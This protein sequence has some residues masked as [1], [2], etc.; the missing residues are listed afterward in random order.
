MNVGKQG[1][2]SKACRNKKNGGHNQASLVKTLENIIVVVLEANLIGNTAEWIVDTGATRHVCT[3]KN[4]FASYERVNGENVFMGNSAS[5]AVQAKGKIILKLTSGKSLTLINVLHMPEMRRNLIYGSLLMKAGLK[6]S[7]DSDRLIITQNGDFSGKD[8]VMGGCLL[9]MLSMKLSKDEAEGI[10][11][12][13]KAEVENQPDKK[14]KRLRSDRGG[15]QEIVRIYTQLHRPNQH[16]GHPGDYGLKGPK[17]IQ[18]VTKKRLD[19][20]I[21]SSG[22]RLS[23]MNLTRSIDT[24]EVTN[25]PRGCKPVGSK[26]VFKKKLK[27]D[28]SIDKY[29]A[30]LVVQGFTQKRA[31]QEAE[32]LRTL[33]ADIPLWGKPVASVAMHCD[34]RAAIDNARNHDFK[35]KKRHILLRYKAVR[36]LL[37]NGVISLDFVKSERNI[38]DPLTKG[39]CRKLVLETS[40][41]MGLKPMD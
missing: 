39:L 4:M 35:G 25:F 41:E 37:S 14:I 20:L 8:F 16:M 10:F 33:L 31:G 19:P 13:Y 34:S 21:Q 5:A 32:W 27:P 7:F 6:L 29:K 18:R 24:W 2:K 23:T 28:G 17:M 15:D 30:R 1:H 38:A 3:S 9:L 36:D 11:I 22:K 40:R 12:P 26:W